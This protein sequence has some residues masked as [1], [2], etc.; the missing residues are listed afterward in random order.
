[1]TAARPSREDELAA[2]CRACGLCC[3]GALFGRVPLAPDEAE[4]LRRRG[5]RVV[6]AGA[7]EQPCAALSPSPDDRACT[8]YDERPAACRAF[9]CTLHAT[10]AQSGGPLEPRLAVV[11][12]ARALLAELDRAQAAGEE[13]PLSLVAALRGE[14]AASFGRAAAA[15]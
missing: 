8:L 4:P 9:V 7:L 12:R 6:G 13:P 14:L 5:L 3:D 11:R 10:H 1:M 15:K 2:L